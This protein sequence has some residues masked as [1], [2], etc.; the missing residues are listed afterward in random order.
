M[1]FWY[2]N[3]R[4]YILRSLVARTEPRWT[5]RSVTL[6]TLATPVSFLAPTN[7]EVNLPNHGFLGGVHY[8][9]KRLVV[10]VLEILKHW[11]H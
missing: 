4:V 7:G 2:V 5:A 1:I 3:E 8:F 9:L 6:A 11:T 10:M